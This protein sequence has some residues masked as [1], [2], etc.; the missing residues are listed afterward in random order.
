MGPRTRAERVTRAAGLMHQT[1]AR[2]LCERAHP[3]RRESRKNH[4]ATVPVARER[5]R[6]DLDWLAEMR[7]E[8][9]AAVAVRT[10]EI[11][12]GIAFLAATWRVRYWRGCT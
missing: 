4:E 9:G 7:R 3:P 6:A 11:K 1:H 2:E 8:T 10:R 12:G 5:A